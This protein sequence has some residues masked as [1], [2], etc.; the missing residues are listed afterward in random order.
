MKKL[1][2]ATCLIILFSASTGHAYWWGGVIDS[3]TQ[4][5]VPYASVMA[6]SQP[7]ADSCNSVGAFNLDTDDKMV[8]GKY[9]DYLEA[10]KG[11]KNGRNYVERN[12][13]DASN[14]GPFW[15]YISIPEEE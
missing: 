2:A 12:Y 14:E 11:I 5:A 13:Y 8:E 15:I 3:Q 9:Y 1:L 6:W 10:Y 4:Q 7:G